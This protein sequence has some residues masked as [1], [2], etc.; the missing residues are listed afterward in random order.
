M[1]TD[2]LLLGAGWFV[3]AVA[4]AILIGKSIKRA[5]EMEERDVW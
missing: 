1:I 3:L 5:D 2:L 4:V